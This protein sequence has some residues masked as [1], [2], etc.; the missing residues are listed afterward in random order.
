MVILPNGAVHVL[1]KA[2][3]MPPASM[4]FMEVPACDVA[5]A[6]AGSTLVL[7]ASNR[8]GPAAPKYGR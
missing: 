4:T 7:A 3:A 1:E 5:P 2:P 6:H 8:H